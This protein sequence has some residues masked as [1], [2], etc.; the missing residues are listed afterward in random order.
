MAVSGAIEWTP[1]FQDLDLG[2]R[3]AYQDVTGTLELVSFIFEF[4]DCCL[5]SQSR[6][7]NKH[8]LQRCYWEFE[9]PS[10][11]QTLSANSGDTPS[12]MNYVLYLPIAECSPGPSDNLPCTVPS[13][14]RSGT[15]IFALGD[16]YHRTT[17]EDTIPVDHCDP[18]G[19]QPS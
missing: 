12:K 10:L 15:W 16:S 4:W 11:C 7:L 3:R 5:S 18:R 17:E 19:L 2:H 14:Y 13:A 6:H 8:C 9:D 1:D